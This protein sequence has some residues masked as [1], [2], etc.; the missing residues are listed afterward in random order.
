MS[1]IAKDGLITISYSRLLKKITMVEVNSQTDFVARSESFRNFVY[2]LSH[3][4]LKNHTLFIKDI[5]NITLCNAKT[6]N[7]TLNSLMLK[8]GEK[9]LPRRFISLEGSGI[10]CYNHN[11]R[12]G[13]ILKIK[14]GNKY[15]AKDIAMHIAALNPLVISQDQIPYSLLEKERKNFFKQVSSMGKSDLITQKIVAGKISKFV[16]ENSLLGQKFVK[17][18]E[19]KIG[20]LLKSNHA[21]VISFHRF[22][23][24]DNIEE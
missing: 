1:S 4:A 12:I 21:E 10:S 22:L 3:A 24:G 8:V 15:L 23:L 17:N 11:N 20:L 13:V 9:I 2:D 5:L 18:S 19:Q 6:I 7:E 16:D 14:G